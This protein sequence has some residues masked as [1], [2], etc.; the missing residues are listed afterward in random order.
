MLSNELA[1]AA[2]QTD[3]VIFICIAVMGC[4]G[5]CTGFVLSVVK[6]HYKAKEQKQNSRGRLNDEESRMLEQMWNT[7]QKMEERIMNLETILMQ[8]T[9][10]S[11]FERKL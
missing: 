10:E 5:I 4:L 6:M 7:A 11:T 3:E 9:S 1:F 2:N 8:R